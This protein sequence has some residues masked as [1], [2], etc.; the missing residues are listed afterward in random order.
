MATG[1]GLIR[2]GGCAY[3]NIF[4]MSINLAI[5]TAVTPSGVVLVVK[6]AVRDLSICREAESFGEQA[7]EANGDAT[8]YLTNR[9]N[10]ELLGKRQTLA[11]VI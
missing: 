3:G 11:L 9:S 5:V 1:T 6:T 4:S 7:G 2:V 10:A 8:I